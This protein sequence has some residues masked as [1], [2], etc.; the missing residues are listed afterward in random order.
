MQ[1]SSHLKSHWSQH[2]DAW[3]ASGLSQNAYCQKH[4]LRPNQFTYW[5]RKLTTPSVDSENKPSAPDCAFI[6]LT[7]NGAPPAA[8]GLSLRLPNGCELSGIETRHLPIVTQ[9]IEVLR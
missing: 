8:S 4:G 3:R 6:P 7:V 1:S 2:L 9:L 5:K